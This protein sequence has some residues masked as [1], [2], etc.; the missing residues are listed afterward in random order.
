MCARTPA[1]VFLTSCARRTLCDECSC[2][3]SGD[4]D[5][6]GG[7]QKGSERGKLTMRVCVS[8][9]V[10]RRMR[11]GLGVRL[12]V[13]VCAFLWDRRFAR[14]LVFNVFV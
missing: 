10:H 2:V 12:C 6:G 13:C 1:R 8:V 9:S 5:D 11:I 14:G 3:L 7:S 4:D